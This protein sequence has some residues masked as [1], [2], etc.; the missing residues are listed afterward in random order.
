VSDD[1]GLPE[2]DATLDPP[3]LAPPPGTQPHLHPAAL[4]A[5]LPPAPEC[6]PLSHQLLHALVRAMFDSHEEARAEA[7]A[8]LASIACVPSRACADHDAMLEFLLDILTERLS[9]PVWHVRREAVWHL[10]SILPAIAPVPA[11]Q[12]SGASVEISPMIETSVRRWSR[13]LPLIWPL[14]RDPHDS[15]RV[16]AMRFLCTHAPRLVPFGFSFASEQDIVEPPLRSG[17]P[18]AIATA[19][20]ER[21]QTDTDLTVRLHAAKLVGTLFSP[22]LSLCRCCL[23]CDSGARYLGCCACAAAAGAAACAA[24]AAGGGTSAAGSI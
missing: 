14:L 4:C 15:L 8:A 11:L 23:M 3:P 10:N 13:V 12:A 6:L 7:A 5:G 1:E 2:W 20:L 9:S 17:L 21:L 18:A 16:N 24:S 19:V 22:F